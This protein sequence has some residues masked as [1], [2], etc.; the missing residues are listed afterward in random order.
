V[1]PTFRLGKLA[2]ELGLDVEG[3][4]G[5]EIR[6]VAG[7]ESAGASDLSFVRSE[8]FVSALK[9]SAA[10]AVIAPPGL[11]LGGRTALRSAHPVLDFSRAIGFLAPDSRPAP[12]IH[13]GARV[14]D[15]ATVEPSATLGPGCSVGPRARIGARSVL[16][17]SVTVYADV[18]IGDDCEVH[19]GSSLSAAEIGDRVVIH[20]GVVVG[21]DGFGYVADERGVLTKVPQV[22]RVVIE[23][24]VEIGANTTVDR[25]SL[26]ETRIGR[27][28]KIDNLVQIAHNCRIGEGVL[29]A[30]QVGLAGST[31]IERGAVLMG[32]V[33]VAG[34]L[35]I[36]ERAFVGAKCGVSKDVPAGARVWGTPHREERTWHRIS[37]A[38]PRLPELIRRIRV[39]ERRLGIDRG[40][41][42]PASDTTTD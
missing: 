36:G 40:S 16:H 41:D 27:H 24:D 10:G 20:P 32:Q 8:A 26:G 21:A 18:I 37:A 3:D 30:A 31:R 17:A 2:D 15:S 35:T 19:A 6:G 4:P 25:G 22:G 7:L 28:T 13:P 5:I 33:G 1:P 29:I 9:E 23:D 42:P 39:L 11:D 34:H 12:G 38:L 14:D